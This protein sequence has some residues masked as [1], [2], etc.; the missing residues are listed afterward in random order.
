MSNDLPIKP[1]G[2]AKK[3]IHYSIQVQPKNQQDAGERV[4]L[5][6]QPDEVH[7][8]PIK[9]E[10]VDTSVEKHA[11][12]LK[13]ALEQ[14]SPTR[15]TALDI[16]DE[17]ISASSRLNTPRATPH[18]A[19]SQVPAKILSAAERATQR[20]L[21][22]EKQLYQDYY[23]QSMHWVA[24]AKIAQNYIATAVNAETAVDLARSD[25]TLPHTNK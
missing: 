1:S 11:P 13:P 15:I 2:L 24:L 19:T 22:D 4:A 9:S 3:R 7:S 8:Q 21:I 16:L 23:S 14:Q 6:T 10:L 17:A 5:P 12:S 25:E 18:N 20:T